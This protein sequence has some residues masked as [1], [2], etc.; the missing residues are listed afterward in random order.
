M[1]IGYSNNCLVTHDSGSLNVASGELDLGGQDFNFDTGATVTGASPS[2][3]VL[4]ATV[5]FNAASTTLPLPVTVE[6]GTAGTGNAV[7][8]T[9]LT[10]SGQLGGSGTVTVPSGSS[11]TL[12]G[13]QV[14][15]GELVNDGSGSVVADMSPFVA[16]GAKLVNGGSLS[17]AVG[18][19]LFG[20]CAIP[21]TD[22]S[23]GV[24]AG[25]FDNTGSI[26]TN[27]TSLSGSSPVQI[28]YSNNCLITHDSGS[29]DVASGELDLGG[30]DFNFDTGA[31]VT[32]GRSSDLVLGATISFN[33][34]STTLPLP[35]A[36]E[37][38]TA[39]SGNAVASA[40]LTL[41]GELGG[42]GTVTVPSGSSLTLNSGQI[43]SGELVND[44]SGTV[45]ANTGPYV[46][47]G[48]KLVNNGSLSFAVG[49]SIYGGCAIPPT[50]TS[51]G[52]PAG[53]F[54]NT[55]G[56]TTNGKSSSGS[57]PVEI[58]YPYNNCLV[59]QDSGSLN[60]QSGELDLA[61]QD[62]NF[63]TGSTVTGATSSD[64]VLEGTVSFN[65]AST[66]L[67]LATIVNGTT[68]GGGNVVASTSL[69]LPGDLDGS[70]TV[71][72]PSGSSLTLNGGEVDSGELVNDGSGT[73]N[74]DTSQYVA[75]G[76]K[77]V[78]NGSLSF[79]VGSLLYGGCAVP[80]TDTSPGTPAGELDS[81][82][83][84]TT[85]GTSSSGSSPVEIGYPYN[86][87]LVT[88]DSGSL[89]VASGELDLAGQDFNFDTDAT[90]SGAS[91]AKLVL[92]GTVSFNSANTSLPLATIVNG[93]TAGSGNVVA[94]TSLTLS[95]DL[96]GSGT[97]TV[98][99]GSSLTLN[100]GQ[101][102][103]GELVND[104]SGSVTANTNQ[105]VASGAK[106]VNN[107]SLSFAVGS[108]LYGG[109]AIPP[110][111]TSS[112]VPAGEFDSTGSITSNGKSS[113]GSSP[114]EIGYP[115]NNCLVTQDSGSLNVQS[116]ELDLAGQDFN[117][118]TGS[119]VTGASSSDLVLEGTVSFN[120]ATT[121]LP[122]PVVVE[123]STTGGGNA[124]ASTSLTLSGDLGGSGTV[125]VPSGSS[126][127][128]N[129]GEVDSGELV[130]DGSGSVTANTSQYVASGAKLVNNGSLSFAVGS[131]LYGG[132]AVPPTDTSPGTPAGELDSTGSI[133][134]NGTS[135]SGSSPVEI[136]YPYNNC[137]VTQDSGSLNVASGELDLAG[138]NFNFDAGASGSGAGSLVLEGD[139]TFNASTN[140]Q[141]ATTIDGEVE[142]APG[143]IAHIASLGQASGT[144]QLDGTGN[145]GQLQ[146]TGAA[147]I[148]NLTLSLGSGSYTPGCGA[149][150]TALKAASVSG[151]WSSVYGGNFPSGATW[152]ATTTSTTAGAFVSCP[153]VDVPA[154]DTYGAGSSDDS[155]NPS[156]YQAEPVNTA[157]GAYNTTQTDATLVGLGVRFGFTRSYTSSNA[158]SGPLGTGWTDS[159]NVFLT[160]QGDGSVVLSSE[161][162]QQT[163]FTPEGNGSYTAAPGTRSVLSSQTGG[164]WL[165]VRQ[166]QTHLV[167]N[168]S[169]KL[170]SETD[171]NGVGLTLA[172]NG[173]GQL[174]S[175]TDYAARVVSFS[176]NSAGLLTSMSFP[177]GR[178][179]SYGYNAQNELTSVTDAGGGVTQYGYSPQ[180]LLATITNQDGHQIV[181]NTYDSSARVIKQVNALG[182]GAT[183]SYQTGSTTYTDPD[184][185]AWQDIYN[186]NLL[187]ERVDPTGRITK[188]T[189]D[190]NLDRTAVIDPNGQQTTMTYDSAG[191]MTSRTSPLGETATWSYDSLNDVTSTT[192]ADE[193][194][195]TYAYDAKGNL[196]S[197]TYADGAI[198][199]ETHDPTTGAMTSF[200]DELGNTTDYGYDAQGDLASVASP[201][202]EKTTYS[203]DGAGRLVAM[204]S[205]R[206]NVQSANPASYTTSYSYDPD[207]RLVSVTDPT[208]DVSS[209]TYDAAGNRTS[210]TDGNGNKTSWGYDAANELTSVTDATGAV[211][212]YAYDA[213]GNRISLT[214]P[215]GHQ[216]T[217]SYDADGR[218]VSVTNPLGNSTSYTY[219]ADGERTSVTD[220]TG[221][222]TT[223]AYNADREIA[224]ISY[225][226]GTHAVGYSYDAN[227]NRTQMTDATG[228]TTYGFDARNRLSSLTDPQ[229]TFSYTYDKD[230]HVTDRTYPDTT[231]VSYTYDGDGRLQSVTADGQATSYGYDPDS[232][233]LSTTLPNGYKETASYDAAGRMTAIAD[234]NN[235][236][237]LSSFAYTYDAAGNPTKV[238]TAATSITY[239]YDK[240][241]RLVSACYGTSCAGGSIAYTYDADG[242]RTKLVQNSASTT[243]SYDHADELS[244][245]SGASSTTYTYDGDGRRTGAGQTTYSY[246]AANELTSLKSPSATTAYTYDGDGNR[247]SSTSGGVTTT[248]VYD[249]NAPV[250]ALV[251]ELNGSGTVRRYVWGNGLVSINSGS[252]DYYAAHDSQGSVVALTS[253][254][255]ATE[256]TYSYDPFGDVLAANTASGAPSMPLRYE[257]QYLDPSGL[258]HLGARQLDPSIGAFTTAD[259][260]APNPT[261]PATSPYLYAND[262]PTV[263]QDPTGE[264]SF[265][266]A[267]SAVESV[268]EDTYTSAVS[269]GDETVKSVAGDVVAGVSLGADLGNTLA[270][271]AGNWSAVACGQSIQETGVHTSEFLVGTVCGALTGGWGE[272]ACNAAAAAGGQYL[273]D[274]YGIKT[275][276]GPD[277]PNNY[278]D[279]G[280]YGNVAYD[281]K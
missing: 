44:G 7:A 142:L 208:G 155:V 100:S 147:A 199:S 233:L 172:Y 163:T 88:Q 22:T 171:R 243:Y 177:P 115:Y 201:L 135:S 198:V 261:G 174:A 77:L 97:V 162:G 153:V 1:Q 41:S 125:T 184:G 61:G 10:L 18:S 187:I 79:A 74:A 5:S 169:G 158:Y 173:S 28:G 109:C 24:P 181:S 47:S 250:P 105:Y 185:N 80:P 277:N 57:S 202:G 129:G 269:L 179:V 203:Y 134:T 274:R 127:T 275:P 266:A 43:D 58:G 237:T 251:L 246:N 98:P 180:G 124:L 230:G 239:G 96:D 279:T 265:T 94:S 69:T 272:V 146:I 224:G 256:A 215:L 37:G 159:M 86:N 160:S 244:S 13:G 53:E 193:N 82:G 114:V 219:D 107:G 188:Y 140:L 139:V 157:T 222:V 67:P 221:A 252:S 76:A 87:C 276:S 62:F 123:G 128:L 247:G 137:L 6:G 64:L 214:T 55:G 121:S 271:C 206:G 213:N 211:T 91:S 130:N 45:S 241:E 42:S 60:V 17:F 110:T 223:Y 11:L 204:V 264:F 3:L 209:T 108:L 14:D 195:T 59:T 212:R 255:G 104:G 116:G 75:S 36:L 228:T 225:S 267:W 273:L 117:F 151:S 217:Y 34:T 182:A 131:L 145:F 39:G 242:E 154:A 54:D 4:G 281:T 51:S 216:T 38:G 103:S 248:F 263:L 175:V 16:A 183:F 23:S 270:T 66:S 260:L 89:N 189:Y 99:S 9:S 15:S 227:G 102:D 258:Y 190:S 63:D 259:P 73:V 161:D 93:N 83:S 229:G 84:I 30:Q 268:G 165:L 65:A 56:L 176:Y 238:V 143:A 70:G 40:S 278:G 27:G 92:E 196:L 8:S 26:T 112:G 200:T 21:P 29:L 113:S 138:Q 249:T 280:W 192:D 32:G 71:T 148:G 245:T 235:S 46:A 170:T 166:D 156:G 210:L 2:D 262:Q 197:T 20:Q 90:V 194:T 178:T 205:P 120:A 122:L 81:T 254:T 12:D 119:T 85:N 234:A 72:V 118:D 106:L 240:D 95:G 231:S 253:S 236:G 152:Q 78:N 168:A 144:L 133:T 50:D 141:L 136:G 164:G 101:V 232:D 191:N 111:D 132:C 207:D 220:A 149:S 35:V 126:L 167:F 25:E 186:G 48:A 68:A 31:T 33:Q 19:S 218:L 52:T 49:S 257:A 226:D 150:V